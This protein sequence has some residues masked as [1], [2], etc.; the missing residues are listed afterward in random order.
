MRSTDDLLSEPEGWAPVGLGVFALAFTPFALGSSYALLAAELSKDLELARTLNAM[1]ATML[2]TLPALFLYA[3]GADNGPARNLWR[4]FWSFAFLAYLVHLGYALAWMSKLYTLVEGVG[5]WGA[6]LDRYGLAIAAAN[7]I[8]TLW[9]ALDVV[10]SWL[11]LEME[12]IAWQRAAI[13]LVVLTGAFVAALPAGGHLA[14]YA[15]AMAAALA[16]GLIARLFAPGAYL[17]PTW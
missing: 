12:W 3:M 2:L 9:W 11:E 7:L 17:K 4:L 5:L 6:V 13:Q 16:A 1:T 15:Y 14:P 10:W 8:I